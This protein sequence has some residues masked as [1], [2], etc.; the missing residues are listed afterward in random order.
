MDFFIGYTARMAKVG[1]RIVVYGPTGSGKTTVASRLARSLGLPHIELDALFW[2]PNWVGRPWEEFR[3]EVSAALDR[4]PDGWVIDGNYHRVR[5][6]TLPLADTVVWLRLPLW[7]A[8]RWLWKRTISRAWKRE[9]L[10]GTNRESWRLIFL[11]RDSLLLYQLTHWRRTHER[12]R[13][14]LEQVHH[15]ATVI[16]LHSVAEIENFLTS[17]DH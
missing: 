15:K 1:R 14:D 5:D 9:L 16:E 11:S 10:W 6:L 13:Q 7:V 17:L 4:C 8:F 12:T 2:T 3:A